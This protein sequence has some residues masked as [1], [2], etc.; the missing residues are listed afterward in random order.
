MST[1]TEEN[2]PHI[3]CVDV[4]EKVKE[5]ESI[6]ETACDSGLETLD[7]CSAT[8]PPSDSEGSPTKSVLNDLGNGTAADL[9]NESSLSSPVSDDNATESDFTKNTED[10]PKDAEVTSSDSTNVD[11]TE[12]IDEN[13]E[14]S[15]EFQAAELENLN[16]ELT[17]STVSLNDQKPVDNA[18]INKS[19]FSRSA[20]NISVT[21]Q[22]NTENANLNSSDKD[23]NT[24]KILSQFTSHKTKISAVQKIP[25]NL[26]N[27]DPK[28][29]RIPK[30]LLSQDIGSI[31]KNVHGIFSSVS[32]SL[33]SA[34]THRTAYV[35]KP[36]KAVKNLPNGKLMN[37]IF[38]DEN[39]EQKNAIEVA[40]DPVKSIENIPISNVDIMITKIEEN[41]ETGDA[42]KDVLRLQVESLERLLAEQRKENAS[43]RERVKQ[44]CDELQ[45]KDLTFK[46]LE[47]KLDL[48]SKRVEH[49]ERE[50]DAAVMR[51]ASVE[52]AAIEARRAADNAAKAEK[53]AHNE[54]ELLNGKLKSA[55]GEKQRICQLYDDKCHELMNTERELAKLRED[56]RELDG[57]LK[58]TQSKLRVEMDAYKE[59]SERADKL[60]QQVTELEAAKEAAAANAT[61]S[62]RAKQLEAKL[63]ESQAALIL[64][65]HERDELERRCTSVTSQLQECTSERDNAIESLTRTTAQV[66]QLKI[67]NLRLEEEAAELAALRAKAALADTL[68]A[69]LRRETE[70]AAQAEEALSVERAVAETCGRREAAALEHAAKLTAAHVAN[71]AA[72]ERHEAEA[73]ALSMDNTSLRERIATLEA[74]CS[75]LQTALSEETDR[76]NKENRVLARK[77]AELTE[78]VAELNKKLEWEKGENGVLKK[79]H[80]SAIKELNRELQRTLKR[81]EQLEAKLPPPDAPSTRTGSVSSLSSGESAPQEERLQNGHTDALPDIQVREPDRQTLIERIVSLQRAA[82]RRAERCEFLEEHSKQLTQELRAKAR[83]LR[84]LLCELPAGAVAGSHRDDNKKEIARLGGGAMAAVWGG[85]PGGMTAELSLEMNRRLQAVLEDTLLKNIT[86]KENMDTLGAEI[87]RLKEQ[88]KSTNDTK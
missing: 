78:E 39:I 16:R 15:P 8:F 19:P 45:Q 88:I 20:E 71:S 73:R 32:G 29:T 47:S 63:K 34:Y 28:Y 80:A 77:V 54:V 85:D 50:K 46:D 7:S 65:R 27:L 69:Q 38:E 2:G 1:D 40:E 3:D 81:C 74:D 43:L 12:K 64:C 31:V 35:Q 11:S 37:D 5:I 56:L 6:G 21:F 41:G 83:V 23:L 60:A 4:N 84:H 10:L 57:R 25:E 55:H 72:V 26:V 42:K 51:Y 18:I 59:S 67:S 33:K 62:A 48:M 30:E 52:C 44:Q 13:V 75:R 70:R 68:S 86:L 53:N 61:D 24:D 22:A 14:N 17:T 87:S 9:S 36:T 49:A 76:R 58:W 79:K 66:E 82:A